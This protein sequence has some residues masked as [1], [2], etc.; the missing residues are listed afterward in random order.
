MLKSYDGHDWDG[1]LEGRP[2]S[3]CG[4]VRVSLP[5]W[6]DYDAVFA[7]RGQCWRVVT[8]RCSRNRDTPD[9]AH[10]REFI[11]AEPIDAPPWSGLPAEGSHVAELVDALR[12]LDGL[13]VFF[14]EELIAEAIYLCPK[15]TPPWQST[16]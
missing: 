5:S 4:H 7:M 2:C 10:F 14:A 13:P 9:Y 1:D 16:K 15:E 11:H 6:V 8:G 3:K 12:R